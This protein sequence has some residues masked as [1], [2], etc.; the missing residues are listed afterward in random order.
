MRR[1]V[2]YQV[3]AFCVVL[4][5]GC[6]RE[7]YEPKPLAQQPQEAASS[8]IGTLQKLVDDQNYWSLGFQTLDEVKHARLGE[9]IEVYMIG[10]EKLKDYRSGQDPSSLLVPSAE[11]IYPVTVGGN[12]RTGLTII[13]K[14]Q[15]YESSSFGR[16]DV[17]KRLAAYRKEPGEFAVRIPAF[18][19]Y[20]IGKHAET[21]VILV[22][23]A[24]NPRLRV[25]EGETAPLEAIVEQL[26]PYIDSYNGI[27]K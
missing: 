7:K 5:A 26:R 21:H 17:V 20:F 4:L 16:A 6:S 9:P 13:H 14:E 3:L 27:A 23:I 2:R 12:V 24:N 25:Q 1:S 15:G 10:L 22:S 18:N 8:A 11:T 19:L